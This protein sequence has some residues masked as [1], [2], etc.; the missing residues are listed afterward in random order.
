MA[1]SEYSL[2][3]VDLETSRVIVDV[4][5][6]PVDWNP[7]SQKCAVFNMMTSDYIRFDIAKSSMQK[8]IRRGYGDEAVYWAVTMHNTSKQGRSNVWNRLLVIAT[9]DVG[10][11]NVDAISYVNYLH[12]IGYDDRY[13]I[14]Q[15]A[16]LLSASTKS[17]L[18]DLCFH[19]YRHIGTQQSPDKII[20]MI[21]HNIQLPYEF[22]TLF[23][24]IHGAVQLKMIRDAE[25]ERAQEVKQAAIAKHI[26]NG[27][28]VKHKIKAKST[29]NYI[30]YLIDELL[31]I[32]VHSYPHLVSYVNTSKD[33]GNG[34]RK[35]HILIVIQLIVVISRRH[36]PLLVSSVQIDDRVRWLTESVV[37]G[38][39]RFDVPDYSLDK[40]TS[41]GRKMLR[42]GL[43][44]FLTIASALNNRGGE[45]M[46]IED[47]LLKSIIS[48][49]E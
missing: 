4:S 1:S 2:M 40:H 9:E 43:Q 24:M 13:S 32:C 19:Y 41:H 23:I 16:Y 18:T 6:R 48:R 11:A 47:I 39:I 49:I 37:S 30:G 10:V 17:R 21:V 46:H 29:V 44:H 36:T 45:W 12:T 26:A 38:D 27:G 25:R 20:E 33:L 8:A 15:A 14:A 5:R 34:M 3:Y 35:E 28:N 42:R 22:N 7:M 31:K